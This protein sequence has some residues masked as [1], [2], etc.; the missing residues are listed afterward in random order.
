MGGV[1]ESG[2]MRRNRER[3]ARHQQLPD[4]E[5]APPEY[6]RGKRLSRLLDEQMAKTTRRQKRFRGDRFQGQ[7]L[8]EV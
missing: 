2:A 8:I 1:G 3:F 4:F 6:L 7:R 5:E